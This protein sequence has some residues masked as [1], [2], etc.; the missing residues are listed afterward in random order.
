MKKIFLSLIFLTISIFSFSQTRT[1]ILSENN[2][3]CHLSKTTFEFFNCEPVRNS[4]S[5]FIMDDRLNREIGYDGFYHLTTTMYSLYKVVSYESSEGIVSLDV[6]S[7]GGNVYKYIFDFSN[8][9]IVAMF[10]NQEY[11]TPNSWYTLVFPIT[12]FMVLD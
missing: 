4:P 12:N 8:M 11:Q 9:R 5:T 6:V 10:M 1:Y 7:D 3:Y 2:Q